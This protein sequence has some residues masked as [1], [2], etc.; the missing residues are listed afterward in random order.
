MCSG[1]GAP[2]ADLPLPACGIMGQV[3]ILPDALFAFT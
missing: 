2:I 3:F 1:S